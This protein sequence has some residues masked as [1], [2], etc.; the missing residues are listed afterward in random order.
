MKK[1]MMI[2]AAAVMMVA[3]SCGGNEKKA[4]TPEEQAV[5]LTEDM[6]KA[7]KA[8]D[9]EGFKKAYEAI[10]ALQ[11]NLTEEQ[12][13]NIEKMLQDKFSDSDMMAVGLFMF[14]HMEEITGESL[15]FGDLTGEESE[16]DW[17]SDLSEGLSDLY[18][19]A[20]DEVSELY[21]QAASEASKAMKEAQDAASKAMKEA[22]DQAAQAMKDA[23][24]DLY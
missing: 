12:N 23:L 13:E 2:L 24:K 10:E 11:E 5:A 6:V 22:S 1:I 17:T 4:L 19:D 15:D 21:G 20:A 14:S 8:N 16:E 18:G 7:A 3:V 9:V